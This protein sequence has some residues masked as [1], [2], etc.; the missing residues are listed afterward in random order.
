MVGRLCAGPIKFIAVSATAVPN[1]ARP[2]DA[3][4][5]PRP[6]TYVFSPGRFFGGNTADSHLNQVKFEDITRMLALNL[7]KQNYFPTKDVPSANLLLMVHW[8]MTHVDRN[9]QNEFAA[10]N[11]NKAMSDYRA[12]AANNSGDADPGALN[13]ALNDQAYTAA[14]A[15]GAIARNAA[16]LGYKPTLQKKQRRIIIGSDEITMSEE[17]NEERYFVVL[18]AYDYQYMQKEHKSRLLWVTR[19]SV[20]SPGNNFTEAMPAIAQAGAGVYG[21]QV[22]GLVRVDAPGRGGRVD[23]GELKEIGPVDDPLPAKAKK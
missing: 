12:S 22:D 19:I 2:V 15:Q 7:A 16:L 3:Q 17:L 23:L 11:L 10:E 9:P 20:R 5:R 6:E 13:E 14:S 4:G 1:Y 21:R 8:G 18:M